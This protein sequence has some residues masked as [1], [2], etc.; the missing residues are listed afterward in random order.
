MSHKDDVVQIRN[1]P[2]SWQ[3][4]RVISIGDEKAILLSL[5]EKRAVALYMKSSKHVGTHP[6]VNSEQVSDFK[7]N[8]EWG[9][10]NTVSNKQ[11]SDFSVDVT[12]RMPKA[13]IIRE[14][15]H[16]QLIS[17]H[18][19]IDMLRPMTKGNLIMLKGERN[20]GKTSLAMNIIQNYLKEGQGKVVYVGMSHHGK[21]I[22]ETIKSDDL[23]TIG[24]DDESQAS[25]VLS[26]QVAL[27]VAA[28][29]K[30]CLLVFDDVLLH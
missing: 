3:N 4:G 11:T 16:E 24:V 15:N 14:Q 28:Q 7:I 30:R 23:I 8:L 19:R 26:P 20:T 9:Q 25:F 12:Q 13:P 10:F 27:R 1:P 2:L 5:Q 17:G 22:S 21:E 29:Q 6:A 18:L